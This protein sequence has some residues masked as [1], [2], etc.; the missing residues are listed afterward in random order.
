[1]LSSLRIALGS[2]DTCFS[3]AIG[4]DKRISVMGAVKG[5]APYLTRIG[6]FDVDLSLDGIIL[7][8]RPDLWPEWHSGACQLPLSTPGDAPTY[9]CFLLSLLQLQKK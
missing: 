5:F 1:M 9:L 6:T 8:V 7:L 3:A 4:K 2:S